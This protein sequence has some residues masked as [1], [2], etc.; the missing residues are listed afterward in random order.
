LTP[1]PEPAVVKEIEKNK[2]VRGG[3]ST[4]VGSDS[5]IDLRGRFT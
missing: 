2:G 5:N 3:R 4:E 1:E